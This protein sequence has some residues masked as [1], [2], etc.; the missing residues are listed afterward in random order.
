[1]LPDIICKNVKIYTVNVNA[2]DFV[3]Q[4]DLLTGNS[5]LLTAISKILRQAE[6]QTDC[7]YEKIYENKDLIVA[8]KKDRIEYP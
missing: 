3:L 6:M 7:N 2:V 5:S 8:G 1:M 4:K